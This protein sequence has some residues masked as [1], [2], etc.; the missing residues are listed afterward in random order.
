LQ[1]NQF[2][3]VIWRD[4]VADAPFLQAETPK[5]AGDQAVALLPQGNAAEVAK[6]YFRRVSIQ[7][8][9]VI[10]ASIAV[11]RGWMPEPADA[12]ITTADDLRFKDWQECR[13]T[14]GRL[15]QTLEDLR[16]VGFSL[17]TGLLTA[18][19]F[20][21]FLGVQTTQ[22]VPAPS[23]DVRAAVFLA[24]MVLVAALF[25]VDTYYQ[26]LLSGAIERALDL[27]SQTTPPIR[28]TKYL[29]VNGTRSAISYIILALYLVL[30]ATAEGLGLLAAGGLNLAPP[31]PTGTWFWVWLAGL[32]SLVPGVVVVIL[33]FLRSEPKPDLQP[34]IAGILLP[35]LTVGL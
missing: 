16:K 2:D 31:L 9:T 12:K 8:W 26:V 11:H 14:I 19:A 33:A 1:A 27:E 13:T 30:L 21:N 20:L 15:D 18:G 25:S 10:R 5:A 29:S 32:M 3:V 34:V 7:V 4:S 23:S 22:G 6:K 24:V 35:V 28:V 17:I